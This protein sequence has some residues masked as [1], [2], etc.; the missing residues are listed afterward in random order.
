MASESMFDTLKGWQ[1]FKSDETN[2]VVEYSPRPGKFCYA[3]KTS[4][5]GHLV[6]DEY[7]AASLPTGLDLGNRKRYH[8]SNLK[9]LPKRLNEGESEIHF[10]ISL[11][12]KTTS[13]LLA[14]LKQL[15]RFCLSG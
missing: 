15:E 3:I 1:R 14:L 10:G 4:S 7:T 6:V 5:A 2:K 8:H 11:K 12:P 9:Q 13:D